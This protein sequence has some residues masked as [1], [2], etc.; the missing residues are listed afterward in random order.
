MKAYRNILLILSFGVGIVLVSLSAI[1]HLDESNGE[2]SL[3][4]D[5]TNEF[6][7]DADIDVYHIYRDLNRVNDDDKSEERLFD[8]LVVDKVQR[9]QLPIIRFPKLKPHVMEKRR[10]PIRAWDLVVQSQALEFVHIT[11]T[12]GSAIEKAGGKA[13]IK[14]G[15]CHFSNQIGY[16]KGCKRPDW[17]RPF[18]DTIRLREDIPFPHFRGEQWHTPPSWIQNN[19]YKGKTTFSV[20]RN[21][22]DRVVSEF[23][24]EFFGYYRPDTNPGFQQPRRVRH[25]I[26]RGQ[27][28]K[29]SKHLKRNRPEHLEGLVEAVF[30]RPENNDYFEDEG[31]PTETTSVYEGEQ[32]S[33]RRRLRVEQVTGKL[34]SMPPPT[35]LNFN[36][37][38]RRAVRDLNPITGHMYPQH[39]YVYDNVNG[40]TQQVVDHILRFENL[41]DEFPALMKLYGLSVKLPRFD[42]PKL[43]LAGNPRL[44]A[45]D[46]DPRTIRYI[47]WRYAKDFDLLGYNKL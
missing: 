22:Y 40:T 4:K 36:R 34:I 30:N 3:W 17:V 45:A 28:A 29:N 47:N 19:P 37:W 14:W 43:D 35:R 9:R 27:T 12:G 42:S 21:P 10:K 24:C 26:W 5:K 15:M 6:D 41:Q 11:K 7:S 16:G 8:S 46:L 1:L 2:W 13:G 38:I 23:Y 32:G 31:L 25:Q 33:S 44:T 20:V 18:G 39:Y